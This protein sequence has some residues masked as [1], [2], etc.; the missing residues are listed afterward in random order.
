MQNPKQKKFFNFIPD[1]MALIHFALK[2]NKLRKDIDDK[3]ERDWAFAYCISNT[4]D[5]RKRTS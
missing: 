2:I 5:Y 3:G 1:L 4:E